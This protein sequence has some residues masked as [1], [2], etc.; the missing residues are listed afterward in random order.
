M[1]QPQTYRRSSFHVGWMR[2][3]LVSDNSLTRCHG[4]RSILFYFNFMFGW[5]WR[6]SNARP[7]SGWSFIR[8]RELSVRRVRCSASRNA[9][10]TLF[11][12]FLG[13]REGAADSR[14]VH[15]SNI[16]YSISMHG[17]WHAFLPAS[18]LIEDGVF[19]PA[20]RTKNF[21]I[22]CRVDLERL[23]RA[24]LGFGDRVVS[25]F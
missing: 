19:S 15:D 5:R 7:R 13:F 18:K 23:V 25:E 16:H 10:R 24:P 14:R 17:D 22:S 12:G 11:L 9:S 1:N 4:T 21:S 6:G 3:A 2:G 20:R 8:S